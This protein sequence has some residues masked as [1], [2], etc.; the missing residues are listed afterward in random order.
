L[1]RKRETVNRGNGSFVKCFRDVFE[2]NH[3]GNLTKEHG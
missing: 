3:E 2:L 1:N